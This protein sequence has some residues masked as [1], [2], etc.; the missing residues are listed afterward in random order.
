[1]RRAYDSLHCCLEAEAGQLTIMPQH[2]AWRSRHDAFVIY[3]LV[4]TPLVADAPMMQGSC[5]YTKRKFSHAHARHAW[6]WS[7]RGRRAG[8]CG[9]VVVV[10]VRER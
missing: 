10:A 3:F 4:D 2:D 5:K 1:M 9:A 8:V 6:T 7:V